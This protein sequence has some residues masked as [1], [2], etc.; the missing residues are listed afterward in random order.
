M[1]LTVS[2]RARR[3]SEF[4][5]AP[6]V[7]EIGGFPPEHKGREKRSIQCNQYAALRGL[8]C[9]KLELELELELELSHAVWQQ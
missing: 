5:D 7:G 4:P 8:R 9:A 2:I 3:C 6:I 1:R